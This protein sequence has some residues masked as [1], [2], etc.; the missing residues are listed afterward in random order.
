[1]KKIAVLG[2]HSSEVGFDCASLSEIDLALRCTGKDSL[3][4]VYANPQRAESDL[5]ALDLGVCALTFD[6]AE[7]LDKI[8]R[9]HARRVKGFTEDRASGREEVR[10]R[11]GGVGARGSGTNGRS[12]P[13][14]DGRSPEPPD[15]ILRIVV[16][17]SASSVPLGEKFG[18]DP[19]N[20]RSLTERALD[21]GLP[22]IG[23]SFHCGSGC[24]DPD[25]YGSAIRLAREAVDAIDAV[26]ERRRSSGDGVSESVLL[27]PCFLL[28]IG[29]GYPG[30][31]GAGGDDGRF[32]GAVMTSYGTR[33]VNPHDK[34]EATAAMIADVVCPLIDELFPT[35]ADHPVQVISEPGRYF[36]ESA[37]A[38]CS[39]IYSVRVD[40]D[41]RRHYFIAQGVRGVFKDVLL[42]GETF[43]PVPLRIGDGIV[44]TDSDTNGC[45]V[46]NEER[47]EKD[48][49]FPSTV[50]GPSGEDF[51]V[52]CPDSLL[53]NLI[54]GDWLTFDRMGAYT[55][56]IAA[57]SG[58]LPIR[59]VYS[60]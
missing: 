13:R 45:R 29:G 35:D 3:R 56:S 4:I 16:P 54:E 22:V 9:A 32:C 26:K 52:V 41:G 8:G 60:R 24:H 15:M 18:A 47:C 58:S 57:R 36:V 1:M 25:S 48:E 23:V 50:H 53:P 14:K 59:Y 21:I 7:E 55:L 30:L 40:A 42:C 33:S 43:L 5:R 46:Q 20:V 34:D 44:P 11:I 37:F 2:L 49:L 31:D 28:D 27:R 6:G 19:A 10:S 38:L 12:P 17:D 51:D 39:R